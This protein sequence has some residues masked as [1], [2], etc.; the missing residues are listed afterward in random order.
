MRVVSRLSP[1]VKGDRMVGRGL[2]SSVLPVPGGPI[3]RKLEQ[4][5]SLHDE[6]N[7]KTGSV[8]EFSLDKSEMF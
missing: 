5:A 6:A 7:R 3:I 4:P 1:G 2:A 8:F